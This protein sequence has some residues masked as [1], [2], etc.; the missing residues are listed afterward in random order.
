M[1]IIPIHNWSPSKVK[2][3]AECKLRFQ[4]QYGQKI[5]E[6]PRELKPGQTE[7]ANDRGTRIHQ[8]AED[9]VRGKI[10]FPIELIKFRTEFESLKMLFYRGMAQFEGEWAHDTEWDIVPWK[11]KEAWL[12]LKIDALVHLSEFEAVVIDY[13]TGKKFGNEISHAEQTQSYAVVTF[14]RYPKLELIHTELWYLDL[15]DVTITTF[16]RSQALRLK[17]AME[18]KGHAITDCRV[19]PANPS[20]FT[21]KYCPYG[22]WGTG[23]CT[24]GV[25]R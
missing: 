10:P 7:F 6:P 14:L 15:D 22:S 1:Q 17:P 20:V 8:A 13:K 12:R 16:T 9:Y 11:S 23:H 25:K 5:P 19:F 2:T 24:K 21:C 3:F 4:L 18:R